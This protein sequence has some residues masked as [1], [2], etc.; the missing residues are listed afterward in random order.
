VKEVS[1]VYKKYQIEEFEGDESPFESFYYLSDLGGAL[2]GRHPGLGEWGF[3]Y[4]IPSSG[5]SISAL[6]GKVK[7]IYTSPSS[8][9]NI[10]VG[11]LF[12]RYMNDE[13]RSQFVKAGLLSV[14]ES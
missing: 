14:F 2:Y 1:E 7:D 6:N 4:V 13:E 11:E 9:R 12:K 10:C 3:V 5:A 8:Y